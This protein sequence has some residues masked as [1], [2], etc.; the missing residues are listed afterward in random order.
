VDPL[1]DKYPN[2]SPYTY[3]A[4]NPVRLVEPD[5][6]DI[7]DVDEKGNISWKSHSANHQLFAVDKN[8]NRIGKSISMK[9]DDVVSAY[10]KGRKLF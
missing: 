8:G 9:N 1:A 5:G 6:R 10:L 3:C 7:W 2:L 4:G